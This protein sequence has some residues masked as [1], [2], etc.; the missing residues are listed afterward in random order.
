MRDCKR[1][2]LC[3]NIGGKIELEKETNSKDKRETKPIAENITSLIEEG[4]KLAKGDFAKFSTIVAVF[5]SVDLWVVKSIWYTYMSGKFS[6]Y[7]IDRCYINANNTNVFL[8]I[9]Q[10]VTIFIVWLFINYLFYE[11]SVTED[12]SKFSWKKKR[13]IIFFCGIENV[14]LFVW[15]LLSTKTEFGELIAEITVEK[16]IALLIIFLIL[17]FLINFFAIEFLIEKKRKDKKVNS[18]ENNT[19]IKKEK[20]I[21]NMV[22]SIIATIAFELIIVFCFAYQNEYTR[23]S[24]KLIL[25]QIETDVENKFIIE[26]G[27]NKNKYQIYPIVYENEDCYIVTRLFKENGKIGIDYNY[28]RVI[29]K[30]GQETIY[31][32]NIYNIGVNN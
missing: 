2:K 23:S 27:E 10:L 17:S 3:L 16:V 9:I 32:Q 25:A 12:K 30:E 26:C 29:Q 19:N 15:V 28:Q 22:I 31:I 8:E 21:K 11:I 7:K 6:V 13:N 18:K 14:V 5:F 20:R 24:Y 4:K 1:E